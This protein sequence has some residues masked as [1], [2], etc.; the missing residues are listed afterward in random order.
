MEWV[1]IPCPPSQNALFLTLRNGR[2]AKT[3]IYDAWINEA[4]WLVK[5]ANL[6]KL[7]NAPVM[8]EIQAKENRRRD[9]GN[10]EKPITDLLVSLQ[11]I[12]DDRCA[13]VRKIVMTWG[14]HT[15]VRVTPWRDDECLVPDPPEAG[16]GAAET[17]R[18]RAASREMVWSE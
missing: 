9:L 13:I 7:G 6:Q 11:I 16:G 1:Q 15:C 5:A 10:Y 2:R 18:Q 12:N 4:G 3:K 17:E 14:K 8:I